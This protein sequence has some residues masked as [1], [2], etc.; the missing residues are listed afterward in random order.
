MNNAKK[1]RTLLAILAVSATFAACKQ[2]ASQ[3]VED[4]AEDAAHEVNQAVERTG[5]NVEKAVK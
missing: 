3:K 1:I 5:E 4:K 2:S